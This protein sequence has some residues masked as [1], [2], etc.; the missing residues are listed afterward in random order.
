MLCLT[1]PYSELK[2]RYVV[3]CDGELNR[4]LYNTFLLSHLFWNMIFTV[5]QNIA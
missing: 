1:E 5:L 3:V 2:A 4:V